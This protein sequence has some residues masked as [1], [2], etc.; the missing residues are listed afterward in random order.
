MA[1]N[2]F[3]QV[4]AAGTCQVVGMSPSNRSLALLGLVLAGTAAAAPSSTPAPKG[5]P[6]MQ[7]FAFIFRPGRDVAPA[8][9]PRRNAAARDWALAHRRDGTL[10]AASPLEDSGVLVSKKGVAPVA[11]ERAVAAVLVIAAVDLDGAVALA[12]SHPGL[13][14]GT[15][16]EVRPVK[17]VAAPAARP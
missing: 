6:T 9:L 12:L 1:I 3:L 8:D 7:E 2:D 14:F 15:E 4:A 16:I 17:P 13:A 10:R 11:P 5:T